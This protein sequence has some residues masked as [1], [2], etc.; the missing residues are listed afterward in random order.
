ME[1]KFTVDSSEFKKVIMDVKRLS[2][3]SMNMMVKISIQP[4]SI[5]FQFI[6]IQKILKA[7]TETYCNVLVPFEILYGIVKTNSRNELT[8]VFKD[9]VVAFSGTTLSK[10]TIKVQSLFSNK[11]PDLNINHNILDILRLR[12][13]YD[14]EKLGELNLIEKIEIEEQKLEQRLEEAQSILKFYGVTKKEL[15]N[16]VEQKINPKTE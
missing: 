16:I 14:N 3:H 1:T 12:N 11:T 6:G 7:E 8:L 10:S 5:E 15:E 13:Q 4:Q 2:K 9:G